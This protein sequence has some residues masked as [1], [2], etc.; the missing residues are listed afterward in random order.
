M[1]R[2]CRYKQ[3]NIEVIECERIEQLLARDIVRTVDEDYLPFG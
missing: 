2:F 3:T 1:K